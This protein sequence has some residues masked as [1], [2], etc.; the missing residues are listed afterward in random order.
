MRQVCIHDENEVASGVF[1]PVDVGSAWEG[2]ISVVSVALCDR[3][4]SSISRRRLTHQDQVSS[5]V[6]E[7]PVKKNKRLNPGRTT[8]Q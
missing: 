5:L 8:L 2:K 7:G 6:V 1:H 3:D 4:T